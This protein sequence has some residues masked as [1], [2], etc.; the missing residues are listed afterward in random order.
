MTI[1]ILSAECQMNPDGTPAALIV[2]TR[3]HSD[4]A[5]RIG[6]GGAVNGCECYPDLRRQVSLRRW[7]HIVSALRVRAAFYGFVPMSELSDHERAIL[8][9][10]SRKAA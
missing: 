10:R 2:T 4:R 6:L 9:E 5:W 1:R 3:W 8:V 7:C